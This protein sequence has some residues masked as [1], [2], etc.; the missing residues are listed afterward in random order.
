MAGKDAPE[1]SVTS[2]VLLAQWQDWVERSRQRRQRL[3]IVLLKI[4]Y[5]QLLGFISCS[6]GV[7]GTLGLLAYCRTN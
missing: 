2:A 5:G 1:L 7:P 6:E 3:F 4:S